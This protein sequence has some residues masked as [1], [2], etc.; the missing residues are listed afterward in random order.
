MT[1]EIIRVTIMLAPQRVYSSGRKIKI[2]A[3]EGSISAGATANHS[4]KGK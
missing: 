2:P 1:N 4:K 3:R